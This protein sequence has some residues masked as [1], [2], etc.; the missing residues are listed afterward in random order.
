LA[1]FLQTGF[2]I[3]ERRTCAVLQFS[4]SS[5]RYR[6]TARDQTALRMRLRDLAAARVRYG[7][8]RLHVL[9]QREG[10]HVNHKCVYRLYRLEGLGLR[11]KQRRK[12][13]STVRVEAPPATKPNERWAMDF[14]TDSLYDGRRFRML[15]LVDTVTRECPAIEVGQSL[16]GQRVVAVLNRLK[17]THG[18]PKA[19]AVDNG[20]EFISKALDAWAHEYGVELEFSRPGTPTDNPYIEAFNGRLRDECLDQ[21]WFASLEDAR[22]T[23]ESWRQ[24]YNTERPHGALGNQTPHAFAANWTSA[25]DG[26]LWKGLTQQLEGV[27]GCRNRVS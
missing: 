5:L 13:V 14:M 2:R 23:I 7:Y 24:D 10:W 3:S 26:R 1:A 22:Q 9:L 27:R 25:A 4:R 12:R 8:R 17:A 20:P 11:L 18:L 21:H 15:T 16:T 19:I 6:S